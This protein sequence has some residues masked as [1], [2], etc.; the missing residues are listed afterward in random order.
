MPLPEEVPRWLLR[1]PPS[2]GALGIENLPYRT[3]VKGLFLAGSQ[4]VSGLGTEGELVAA[5]GAARIAGKMD[6]GRERIVRSM[7]SKVEV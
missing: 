1:R 2:N 6:P 5:W 4:V 7:R 3:G